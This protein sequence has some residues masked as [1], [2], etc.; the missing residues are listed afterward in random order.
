M[1]YIK[2]LI[3]DKIERK[4]KLNGAVLITGPKNIGKTTTSLKFC[5]SS[6]FLKES[7]ET[8]L[9]AEINYKVAIDGEKPRLIDEWQLL[10][11]I[12][13]SIKTEIDRI[14]K[15][16]QY[17]LC[18]SNTPSVTKA[19]VLHS[20]AGRISTLI[21]RTMSL[22]EMNLSLKYVNLN[23]LLSKKKLNLLFDG[24]P[25]V[26]D[27]CKIIIKGGWPNNYDLTFEESQENIQDYLES[28]YQKELIFLDS[29]PSPRNIK[30]LISAISRNISHE[31]TL[32]TL[33]KEMRMGDN[34]PSD[35]T[36]R[37]YLDQLTS[38]FILD[39]LEVWKTH[40][41]SSVRTK[42]KPK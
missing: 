42:E 20:G 18:G 10:P 35:I 15:K 7:K 37:T 8:L 21:M 22:M 14:G 2:R 9:R 34:T 39:E 27:Y 1:E 28:I 36:I 13:N 19:E 25:T 24:G 11:F 17:I 3:E 16:S 12:Y 38:M 40:Y 31:T 29:K 41:R 26:E 6:I 32:S 5:K 33:G 30:A 23:D 4:L